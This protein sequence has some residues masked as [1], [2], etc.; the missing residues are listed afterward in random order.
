MIPIEE[1]NEKGKGTHQLHDGSGKVM[2]DSGLD[3][4]GTDIRAGCGDDVETGEVKGDKETLSPQ[5]NESSVGLHR[6]REDGSDASSYKR[7]RSDSNRP[8]AYA[9]TL[10]CSRGGDDSTQSGDT[11]IRYLIRGYR[12]RARSNLAM[13]I[14]RHQV[15]TR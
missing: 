8:L 2:Y 4:D 14:L 11:L 7:S 12:S 1:Y 3:V 9:G 13:A 15:G 10:S 5:R 6:T